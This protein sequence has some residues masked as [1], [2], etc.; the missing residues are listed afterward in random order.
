MSGDIVIDHEVIEMLHGYTK[1]TEGYLGDRGDYAV[2]I[3]GSTAGEDWSQ[4][5]V[6]ANLERFKENLKKKTN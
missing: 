6:G 4:G 5:Q 2:V 1:K 3:D